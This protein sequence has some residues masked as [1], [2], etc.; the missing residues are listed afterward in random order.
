MIS[1]RRCTLLKETFLYPGYGR[2]G[3]GRMSGTDHQP[4]PSSVLVVRRTRSTNT[5]I[6]PTKSAKDVNDRPMRA[7]ERMI[8]FPQAVKA[9][10]KDYGLYRTI[11]DAA[12]TARNS[13]NGRIPRQQAEQQRHFM[14]SISI[15]G[16]LVMVW[17]PP[18]M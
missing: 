9:L 15:V 3:Y 2:Q 17:I 6:Q 4:Q 16:P 13:W 8:Y 1:L 7:M 18:I 11:S 5:K 10:Y 12:Q 14:E